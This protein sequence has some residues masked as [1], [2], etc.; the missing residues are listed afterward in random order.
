[1]KVGL[2]AAQVRAVLAANAVPVRLVAGHDLYQEG[3]AAESFFILQEGERLAM[4]FLMLLRLGLKAG[5]APDYDSHPAL[6]SSPTQPHMRSGVMQTFFQT[7]Q[8]RS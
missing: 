2:L 7:L 3:D 4:P 1:M 5:W 6:V 8:G